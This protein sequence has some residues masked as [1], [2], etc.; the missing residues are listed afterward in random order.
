MLEMGTYTY[1]CSADDAIHGTI[2]VER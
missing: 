2:T 1:R